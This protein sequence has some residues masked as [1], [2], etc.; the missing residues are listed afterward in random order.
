MADH[1]RQTTVRVMNEDITQLSDSGSKD[2]GIVEGIVG[3]AGK[4]IS[5][6]PTVKS[7]KVM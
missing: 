6:P 2:S 1:H 3:D 5:A 7:T 4:T